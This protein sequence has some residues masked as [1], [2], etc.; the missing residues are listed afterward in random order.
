[1]AD[2]NEVVIG[3]GDASNDKAFLKHVDQHGG[4]AL[5]I[6]GTGDP[7]SK[8]V[9]SLVVQGIHQLPDLMTLSKRLNHAL[10]LNVSAAASWM[11]LL[12]GSHMAG[13]KMKTQEASVAHEA[14]TFLLTLASL[15]Q[16]MYLL[17]GVAR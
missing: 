1:M 2:K 4:V 16:S 6:D 13:H 10:W 15:G 11:T 14:P 3:V 12:V 9:A 8:E 7:A 5:V 17:K